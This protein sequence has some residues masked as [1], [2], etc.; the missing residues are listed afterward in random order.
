[1]AQYFKADQN[2]CRLTPNSTQRTAAAWELIDKGRSWG[3]AS[4]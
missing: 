1:M 2:Q 4:L 3:Q